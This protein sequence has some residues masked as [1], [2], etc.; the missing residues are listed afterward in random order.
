MFDT[1]FRPVRPGGRVV[2]SRRWTLRGG[3]RHVRP[4]CPTSHRLGKAHRRRRGSLVSHEPAKYR[5][6][7]WGGSFDATP[8]AA[9]VRTANRE[10]KML[11]LR[12]ED[13]REGVI[14]IKEMSKG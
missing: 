7:H 2:S 10:G 1:L 5:H 8:V 14:L 12:L 4:P 3:R 6:T 11:R 13:G 9:T